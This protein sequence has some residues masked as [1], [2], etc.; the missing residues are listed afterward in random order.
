MVG[1]DV[2]K[3]KIRFKPYAP[4]CESFILRSGMNVEAWLPIQAKRNNVEPEQISTDAPQEK[5]HDDD[6]SQRM[7][8]RII[9]IPKVDFHF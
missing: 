9:E 2:F 6:Q 1:R 8:V 3:C 7:D 5:E 4:R